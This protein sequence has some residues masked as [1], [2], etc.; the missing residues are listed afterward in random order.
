MRHQ[1][2]DRHLVPVVG[3]PIR[4]R[5]AM[6]LATGASLADVG[7]GAHSGGARLARSRCPDLGYG[8]AIKN[9]VED[10]EIHEGG[11]TILSE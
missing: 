4:R 8:Q 9:R 1:R 2:L 6:G 3:D 5:G 7:E 10:V 11:G